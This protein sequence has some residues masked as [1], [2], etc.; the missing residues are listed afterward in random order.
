GSKPDVL[1]PQTGKVI[2]VQRGVV[3]ARGRYVIV[4]GSDAAFLVQHL[5]S[6][7]A[8]IKVGKKVRLGRKIGV[9]GSSTTLANPQLHLHFEVHP[10]PR[11]GN[12]T[13]NDILRARSAVDPE[14]FYPAHGQPKPW[15]R[16]GEGI[17]MRVK[18]KSRHLVMRS[19]HENRKTVAALRPAGFRVRTVL[20]TWRG[21]TI[22]RAN[23]Y[24][25]TSRLTKEK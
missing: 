9:M 6:I 13:L 18:H 17:T 23:R 11:K 21:W 10:H 24:Y 4:R 12:N 8:G 14:D 25:P 15:E 20:S 22:T 5:D 7:P 3:D 19:Y 2:A 1:A 16:P